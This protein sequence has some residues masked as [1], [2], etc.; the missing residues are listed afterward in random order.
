VAG[1]GQVRAFST[2]QDNPLFQPH[3]F[4][5]K[6]ALDEKGMTGSQR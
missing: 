6:Q 4:H 2:E 1:S 3:P 5:A